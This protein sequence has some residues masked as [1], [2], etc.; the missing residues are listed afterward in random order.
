MRISPTPSPFLPCD[1]TYA[2]SEPRPSAILSHGGQRSHVKF[3]RAEDLGTRLSLAR[4]NSNRSLALFFSFSF[5]FF[6]FSFLRLCR[7]SAWAGLGGI[8][9]CK[10]GLGEPQALVAAPSS[11]VPPLAAAESVL[12][13]VCLSRPFWAESIH[14]PSIKSH[15]YH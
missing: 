15:K 13:L 2:I 9:T 14:N 4:T 10:R 8:P 1:V 6:F 11:T 3:A 7:E 5:L 12:D